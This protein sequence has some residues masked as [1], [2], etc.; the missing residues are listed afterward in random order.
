ML[1]KSSQ[2]P[3]FQ[4]AGSLQETS[5]HTLHLSASPHHLRTMYRT[6]CTRSCSIASTL[7]VHCPVNCE[8]RALTGSYYARITIF[9]KQPILGV[10][11]RPLYHD[12]EKHRTISTL[13]SCVTALY[14]F[15]D[16]YAANGAQ[17]IK[18]TVANYTHHSNSMPIEHLPFAPLGATLRSSLFMVWRCGASRLFGN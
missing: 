5:L 1:I 12:N 9:T 13:Q 11:V 7:M 15:H 17:C 18:I 2:G 10:V 8:R 3:T 14:P 6:I 4:R 16:W